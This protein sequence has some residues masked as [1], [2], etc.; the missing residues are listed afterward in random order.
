MKYKLLSTIFYSNNKEY[1]DIYLKR[2]N[3]ESAYRF[4]FN[5]KNSPAFLVIT[6]EI[7]Q[8][9]TEIYK[10]DKILFALSSNLPGIALTQYATKCLIDEIKMTN[11]IEGVH[12]TRKEI[13]DILLGK[14]NSKKR[15]YGL[16]KKYQ[17]FLEES[18]SL[19]TCE[20]IRNIYDELVLKEVVQDDKDNAPD[21]KFF[22]KDG[23]SVL[24]ETGD[25]IHRG[26]YPEEDIIEML[27]SG[28][29][30]L[31]DNNVNQLISIAVFHYLCG[32]VHPFYDGNGRISRFISSYL[33]SEELEPLVSYR[34]AYTIKQNLKEYYKCF[35]ISNDKKNKGDLT[36]FVFFFLDIISKSLDDLINS[37]NERS[38]RLDFYHEKV[39][40]ICK[41]DEKK[42]SILFILVQ[43]A[44]FGESSLS[45]DELKTITHIGTSTLRTSLN[46]F[47]EI[48]LLNINKSSKKHM[49]CIN[50]DKLSEFN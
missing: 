47:N 8:K 48:G 44:L 34:L 40:S 20:D 30:L 17:L 19:E 45:I 14:T 27:S 22:R 16:V 15:L 29:S 5:V 3:C 31:K 50:L 13:N 23:V 4:T 28:I 49:Y 39:Q 18:V 43:D 35:K 37:I 7:L 9:I 12:S 25:I 21:G 32:Y 33:L 10:K 24:S 11:E 42:S 38:E 36:Y 41:S 6:N 26:V 1:E 2:L 46:Y